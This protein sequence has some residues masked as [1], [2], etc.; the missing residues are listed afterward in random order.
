MNDIA[1]EVQQLGKRYRIGHAQRRHDTLRDQI[2][3]FRFQI[4]DWGK[5]LVNPK[6]QIENPKSDDMIWALKDVSFQIKHGEVVGII[7]RNGA[8]KSTLLKILS[9]ITKPTKGYAD[10]HGHVRSLLEVGTGF[11][12]E[13]TGRENIYLSGAILG[14][15]RSEIDRKFDEI[16]AFSEIGKFIDTPVKH[17]SSGMYVRL[18]FGVAAHLEPEILLV[19]EVLAVGDLAFQKKCLGKMGDVAQEGRT[20]LFVSHNMQAVRTLC[21]RTI[22]L[23]N[24]GLAWDDTTEKT[25]GVYNQRLRQVKIDA[26]TGITNSRNRRGSG[27]V[28]LTYI[29]VLDDHDRETYEFEIGNTIR[30]KLSYKVFNPMSQ[31][32]IGVCLRSGSTGEFITSTRHIVSS[33]P[34]DAGAEGTV[35]IEF[36][37]IFLRPGEYPLYFGVDDLAR[38]FDVVDDLTPPLVIRAGK[39]QAQDPNFTPKPPVGYFSIPSRITLVAKNQ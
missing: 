8:G 3:D 35:I 9:R 13:L 16:V 10:I 27:D 5:R 14:M 38:K 30:F 37:H 12:A 25:L 29:S 39:A 24:G 31:M 19:D 22:L 18:A 1:L 15:Q 34:V 20:I 2:S 6:S 33:R 17:F 36:P 23:E 26:N 32:S 11:H 28:R 4:A 7:G 21:N